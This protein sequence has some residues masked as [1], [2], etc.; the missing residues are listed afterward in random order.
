MH[1]RAGVSNSSEVSS[2]SRWTTLR[3]KECIP[4]GVQCISFKPDD[5]RLYLVGTE[6]GRVYY[7]TTEYSSEFLATFL[8]H[9]SPVYSLQWNSFI[10]DIF[11]SCGADWEIKIWDIQRSRPLFIFDL[12]APLADV[13]WAPYSSTVF[14]GATSEGKVHVFDLHISKYSPICVQGEDHHLIAASQ[15]SYITKQH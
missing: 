13:A 1:K 12:A 4:D 5:P 7:C 9:H 10:P 6:L 11:L 8:A 14:A 3:D 15:L 2:T